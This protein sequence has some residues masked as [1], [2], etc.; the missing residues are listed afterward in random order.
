MPWDIKV[1][2]RDRLVSDLRAAAELA[3]KYNKRIAYEALAWGLHVYTWEHSWELVKEVD[4]P[5]LGICLD[6]FHIFSRQG[7]INLIADV[8]VEKIFFEQLADAPILKVDHLSYSRH[9]RNYPLQGAFP[10]IPFMEKLIQAGYTGPLSLEIFNDEFRAAPAKRIAQDGL[11]SLLYL[12]SELYHG[13]I[14]PPLPEVEGIEYVEFAV[15]EARIAQLEAFFLDM[16]L[17][18]VG[19]HRSK[20]V[21]LYR[22]GEF[23][24]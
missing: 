7:D 22:Q 23:E 13:S 6:T 10:I 12:Q 4:H 17:K 21:T 20:N 5:N 11:R 8:P 18:K 2:D 3:A 16:G 14:L 24:N 19:K 9:H 1:G 15:D